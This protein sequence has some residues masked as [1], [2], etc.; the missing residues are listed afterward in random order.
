MSTVVSSPAE[1]K[2]A[3]RR[4]R[5]VRGI[6]RM[7]AVVVLVVSGPCWTASRFLTPAGDDTPQVLAAVAANPGR[8]FGYALLTYVAGATMV[9]AVLAAA[10]LARTRRPLLAMI[11]V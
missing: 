9:P 11:A 2:A 3:G 5:D 7:A 4:I 10:R 1:A 6:E 8:Q